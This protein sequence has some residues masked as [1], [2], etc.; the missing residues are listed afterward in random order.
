MLRWV[1]VLFSL[2]FS[3]FGFINNIPLNTCQITLS[4]EIEF[5]EVQYFFNATVNDARI[6]LALVALYSRPDEDLFKQSNW[7]VWSV[8]EG[9]QSGLRVIDAKSIL[10]VVSVIPH[11][12]HVCADSSDERYFIWEQMGTDMALLSRQDSEEVIGEDD[13]GIDIDQENLLPSG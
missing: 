12:H 11:N 7:T 13:E 5:A 2:S 9:G 4:N 10:S 1:K 6:T 3:L 8:T